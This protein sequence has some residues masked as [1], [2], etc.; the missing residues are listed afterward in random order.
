MISF[1]A[2]LLDHSVEFL[3]ICFA[4]FL[5]G[6]LYITD[7]MKRNLKNKVKVIAIQI[8]LWGFLVWPLM[9]TIDYHKASNHYTSCNKP[10]AKRAGYIY[11][12]YKC[13]APARPGTYVDINEKLKTE[14]ELRNEP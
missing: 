3:V 7:G 13:W 8:F 12:D 6:L 2:Y 10:V 4:G 1:W 9:A 11:S 14:Q 5:F